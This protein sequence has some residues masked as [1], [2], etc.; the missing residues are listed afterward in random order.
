MVLI[1][2]IQHICEV[3]VSEKF[4]WHPCEKEVKASAGR[5]QH[6][7]WYVGLYQLDVGFG[8]VANITC[9]NKV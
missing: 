3:K 8:P 2:D 7:P 9:G 5:G 1:F 6:W 4:I